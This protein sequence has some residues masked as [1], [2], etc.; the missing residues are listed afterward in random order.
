MDKALL[1]QSILLIISQLLL[2]SICLHYRPYP[3]L[4]TNYAPLSPLPLSSNPEDPPRQSQDYLD[5]PTQGEG[6]GDGEIHGAQ[7]VQPEG[8]KRPFNF[9]AWDGFGTYLEFLAG[10]IVVLG[11]LQVILGRWQL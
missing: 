3:Q 1:C 11:I 4:N 6:E 10:L 7:W 9:W 2:L 5:R 8:K